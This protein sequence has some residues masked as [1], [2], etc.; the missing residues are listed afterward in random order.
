M[1]LKGSMLQPEVFQ[2]PSFLLQQEL[3]QWTK[4]R[5]IQQIWQLADRL[6]RFFLARN[7]K[8]V[9][10]LLKPCLIWIKG[11]MRLNNTLKMQSTRNHKQG[12][13]VTLIKHQGAVF[14]QNARIKLLYSI[15]SDNSF[16]DC[17]QL[18]KKTDYSSS[19]ASHTHTLIQRLLLL[20][21]H[22]HKME[23][24]HGVW[25]SKWRDFA[26]S[27]NKAVTF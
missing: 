1:V 15:L 2:M 4:N 9:E 24:K 19:S 17:I 26:I 23:P 22:A 10:L 12:L 20:L 7:K 3:N 25:V 14:L 11:A 13:C 21:L 6:E 18:W 27:N 8:I 16:I 5:R